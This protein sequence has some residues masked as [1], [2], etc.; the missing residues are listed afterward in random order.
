MAASTR[1]LPRTLRDIRTCRCRKSIR[2]PRGT[3]GIPVWLGAKEP[4]R[5]TRRPPPGRRGTPPP[6]PGGAGAAAVPRGRRAEHDEA[7]LQAPVRHPGTRRGAAAAPAC[8][9]SPSKVSRGKK[10]PPWRRVS[11]PPSPVRRP[12]IS[13]GERHYSGLDVGVP[14]HLVGRRVVAVVLAPP[15]AVAQAEHGAGHQPRG[16]L[17]PGR[18]L[19][20]LPVRRV[21][22]QEAELGQHAADQSGNDQLEPRVAE[23]CGH[24]Q[25]PD[26]RQAATTQL[27]PVEA[28]PPRHQPARPHVLRQ[29]GVGARG[30]AA[31]RAG[32]ARSSCS[33]TAASSDLQRDTPS[34]TGTTKC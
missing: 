29:L 17:V 12:A 14:A 22:T 19:E 1:K 15:P 5:R 11:Q 34:R 21:V 6:C 24:E 10:Q 31:A 33:V 27:A 3:I 9:L 23:P 4:P 20:D 2:A 28:V 13:G 25:E 26:Q 30:L 7:Q 32:A 8:R 16:P 18:A